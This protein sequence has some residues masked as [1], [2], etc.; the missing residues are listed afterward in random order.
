MEGGDGKSPSCVSNT[1]RQTDKTGLVTTG[2]VKLTREQ[3]YTDY[4]ANNSD[5][6]DG[7]NTTWIRTCGMF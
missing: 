7:H 1:S 2:F 5:F 4:L 3:I 6:V